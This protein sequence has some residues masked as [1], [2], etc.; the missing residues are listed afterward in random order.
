MKS[1]RPNSARCAFTLG[2]LLLIIVIL[3]ILAAVV[4]PETGRGNRGMGYIVYCMN[5]QRQVA[6]G[7]NQWADD[8]SRAYPPQVSSTN[9]GTAEAF[10]SSGPSVHFGVLSNYLVKDYRVLI[11][12]SDKKKIAATNSSVLTDG[13]VS[14]F[15]NLDAAPN[16][17]YSFVSGDR[18]LEMNHKPVPPGLFTLTTNMIPGWTKELHG[19]GRSSP[20]GV[21]AFAD[22]HTESVRKDLTIVL[23]RQTLATNRLAVP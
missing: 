8:H 2:E 15:F 21:M 16:Q 13:N 5:N 1:P 23:Q 18:H 6:I 22:T 10:A 3:A 17:T 12:P 7:L 9:G 11:C 20:V 19:T 4:L 14:Y